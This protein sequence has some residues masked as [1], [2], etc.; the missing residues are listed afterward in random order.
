MT[1]DEFNKEWSDFIQDFNKKFDNPEV[2][3]QLQAV[4]VNQSKSDDDISL[5]FEH[6]YQ[7]QRTDNLIKNAIEHFLNLDEGH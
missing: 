3:K 7:Q 4:A 1:K 6:I 5:D 2:M